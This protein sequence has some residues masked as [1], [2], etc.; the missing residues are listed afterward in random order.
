MERY[1]EFRI[2]IV[3]RLKKNF[4]ETNKDASQKFVGLSFRG[5]P[6]QKQRIKKLKIYVHSPKNPRNSGGRK[7]KG[8]Q[9]KKLRKKTKSRKLRK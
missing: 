3:Q 6:Y 2:D 4:L 9:T 7:N 1:K 5:F 8:H